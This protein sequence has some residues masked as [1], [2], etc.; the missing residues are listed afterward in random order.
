MF[1]DHNILLDFVSNGIG[2]FEPGRFV[3]VRIQL[4]HGGTH[5]RDQMFVV[6]ILKMRHDEVSKNLVFVDLMQ[7]VVF[8][9]AFALSQLVESPK[10]LGVCIGCDGFGLFL[11]LTQ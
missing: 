7:Y 3:F 1:E 8:A 5:G 9:C 6:V 2:V 10:Q 11:Y 4:D